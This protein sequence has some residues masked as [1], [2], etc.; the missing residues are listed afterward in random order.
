MSNQITTTELLRQFVNQ[1]PGLNYADYGDIKSYRAE[2]AEITRDRTDFYDLL[3]VAQMCISDF[4]AKLTE[5]LLN[6]NDRLTMSADGKLEY[7]TGQYFPTEFRPAANRVIKALLFR[8]FAARNNYTDGNQARAAIRK[9]F[10]R[11]INKL[12]FN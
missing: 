5:Y 6:S 8:E 7:C 2:V 4:D 12:Y 1:R 3:S 9:Y 10:G 11:R